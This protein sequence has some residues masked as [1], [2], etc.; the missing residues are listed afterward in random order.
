MKSKK[1]MYF[2]TNIKKVGIVSLF[3][4][5]AFI[6][7]TAITNQIHNN[8]SVKEI[9][10][11]VLEENE[12]IPSSDINKEEVEEKV[13]VVENTNTE[14][15]NMFDDKTI[16]AKQE[17]VV[18]VE[19]KYSGNNIKATKTNNKI[20]EW[21]PLIREVCVEYDVDPIVL[22][23]LLIKES[24]GKIDAINYNSNGTRDYGAFQANTCWGS[25]FDY[26]R[27]LTDKRYSAETA[28]KIWNIKKKF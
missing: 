11:T 17:K 24:G 4:L 10:T 14:K 1:E 18:N 19:N 16:K 26:Q 25:M 5:T 13:D 22:K 27:L 15:T 12:D 2:M 3:I 23:V 8:K 20:E 7:A 9:K 6:I 28:C 21:M